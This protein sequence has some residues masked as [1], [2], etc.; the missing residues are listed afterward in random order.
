M[1]AGAVIG[2]GS[3]GN[4]DA[5]QPVPATGEFSPAPGQAS[6]RLR[7]DKVVYAEGE[8][9]TVE[10]SGAS[11]A[12][13]SVRIALAA[14]DSEDAEPLTLVR[15]T[16]TRYVSREPLRVSAGSAG[17]ANDGELTVAPGKLIHALYFVDREALPKERADVVSDTAV[18]KRSPGDA[19]EATVE[20]ALSGGVDEDAGSKPFGT[21]LNEGG[22]PVQLATHELIYY[23][24]DAD[25]E[26]RFFAETKA[27]RLAELPLTGDAQ[28]RR[29]LLVEVDPAPPESLATLRGLQGD[30]ERLL[31]SRKEVAGT[32]A[33]VMELELDGYV[34]GVNPRLQSHG[35]PALSE[36]EA[37]AVT[38]TMK[39]VAPP[40]V[41]DGTC[42][43]GSA[44]RP[45]VGTV[46]ALWAFT[47]L[48]DADT[49]RIPAAV[50]D[51]GFAPNSDF[52]RPASGSFVEC[53]MTVMAAPGYRCGRGAALGSPTV[54]NSFFGSRSWHGTGVVTTLGGVVNDGAGAAGVAGLVAEPMLY[55][56]DLAG[57]AFE[58]GLGI[59]KA[60]DDGAAVINISGGYP[61]NVVSRVGPDFDVCS[62]EGRAGICGVVTAAAHA[63]A[64]TVCATLGPIP[65]IGAAACGV[66]TG[67][68]VLAT[69]ACVATLSFGDLRGPIAAGVGYASARGVPVVTSAGNRLSREG[70]PE[71]IRDY[72]NL[73]E[74]RVEAWGMVPPMIPETIVVGAVN[75]RFQNVHFHGDR[76]DVWAPIESAY[77][78][79]E[80]VTDPD[81]APVRE[82]IGGTSAAAPFVAGVVA[83]MQALNPD[84]DP[85]SELSRSARA[86]NVAR[87]RELLR[88]GSTTFDDAELVALG[89]PRDRERSRV[90]DPLAA[91]QA[92][93][94]DRLPTLTGFD[95]SLNFSELLGTDDSPASARELTPTEAATGTILVLP[96]SA[97]RDEDFYKVRVPA[98]PAGR[99][100]RVEVTLSVPSGRGSLSATGPGLARFSNGTRDGLDVGVSRALVPAG[101]E[102]MFAVRG[103]EGEDNVYRVLV[104][105]PELA[106]PRMEITSPASGTVVCAGA[107]VP[108]QASAFIEGFPAAEVPDTAFTW[109]R[110]G[111]AL[112]TGPAIFRT[113]NT[114]GDYTLELRP[115][116]ASSTLA[117]SATL[118]VQDCE[119]AAP[120]ASI[121]APAAD[122]IDPGL[123]YVDGQSYAEIT[124]VGSATD[125][126]DGALAGASLEWRTDQTAFQPALLGTGNSVKV[127]LYGE[128]F[129]TTHTIQLI[130]KDSQ[131]NTSAPI[132]RRIRVWT[133]C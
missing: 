25:E 118:R 36:P 108:L 102:L 92:A 126:E 103:A 45:C 98:S 74:T 83:S 2:C 97:S 52:R 91:V 122:L 99:A 65:I 106:V 49:R 70:L 114:P 4:E 24:S 76:V 105:E 28:G 72:V 37:S 90:I 43:P 113:F 7:M 81:S 47:A 59:R 40:S 79:P 20:P 30:D 34:V 120:T 87:I 67:S 32:L 128:C 119:G 62:A 27:R 23:P 75:D 6:L 109:Y 80:S 22:M 68:A 131:G 33:R 38:H 56:Y 110:D 9:I 13:D 50:L 71:I 78:A 73:D 116:A 46:P 89:L 41:A 130:A 8:G 101:G 66:A 93:A 95:T 51:M 31:V 14:P 16:R 19:L 111:S 127:K 12:E 48:W 58:I 26:A 94:R 112:G 100:Y 21:L 11:F 29:A 69:S 61:C 39:L 15:D 54:G 107:S 5:K 35:A 85:R 44:T 121:S 129:G 123:V 64:A 124:L 18:L 10:L 133:L 86:G 117:D 132:T 82:L 3:E 17:T 60:T 96:G 57:Y 88:S 53:D 63:A 104:G 55:K 77:L 1:L 84:L 125:A 115:Y 42:V